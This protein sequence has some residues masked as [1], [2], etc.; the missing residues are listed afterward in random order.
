M[1]RLFLLVVKQQLH[2][3]LVYGFQ[4]LVGIQRG[5]HI[6]AILMDDLQN[7]Q[8]VIGVILVFILGLGGEEGLIHLPV[9]FQSIH[10]FKD[11][12]L[13]VLVRYGNKGGAEFFTHLVYPFSDRAPKRRTVI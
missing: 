4:L 3:L 8:T 11:Q 2:E 5:E 1:R 10:K 12:L 6:L 9:I 13:A 7:D